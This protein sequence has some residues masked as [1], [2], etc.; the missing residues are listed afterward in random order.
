MITNVVSPHYGFVEFIEGDVAVPVVIK[1][2]HDGDDCLR[3][4]RQTHTK[5]LVLLAGM[6]ITF[7]L[8]QARPPP[9][10]Y[11]APGKS[12]PTEIQL[13]NTARAHL[14]WKFLFTEEAT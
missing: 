9:K 4:G 11:I 6:G 3:R 10:Y 8:R 13:A 2:A 14:V 1:M 12:N 5:Q 7:L